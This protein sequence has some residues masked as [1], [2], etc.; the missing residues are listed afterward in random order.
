MKHY[1]VARTR[2]APDSGPDWNSA[3]IL[4][5]FSLPW[6]KTPP[7]ATDFR[8]LWDDTHLHFRFECEDNE[9]VL[10]KGSTLKERVLGS[11]RVEL[12][13]TPDL[14]LKPYYA[15]EIS[16]KGEA[17]GYK[18]Q[19]YREMDWNWDCPEM[20]TEGLLKEGGYVVVGRLPLSSLYHWGVLKPGENNLHVGV[21]RADYS[22]QADG[23]VHP[24]WMP[25]QSPGTEKADFHVPAAF[26]VFD[27]KS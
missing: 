15:F 18:G 24:G 14:S 12:F 17:L 5:D 19:F 21:F 22:K 26:G 25:W 13:F 7:Q 8:A 9:I 16:P 3:E 10:G 27:L 2:Q 20:A 1:P 23:S 11:D 4:R 6:E